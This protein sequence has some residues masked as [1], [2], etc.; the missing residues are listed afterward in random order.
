MKKSRDTFPGSSGLLSN[1]DSGKAETRERKPT[2]GVIPVEVDGAL[3]YDEVFHAATGVVFR[4]LPKSE[5][6]PNGGGWQPSL[7][8]ARLRTSTKLSSRE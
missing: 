4:E 3:P 2:N 5:K 8:L 1:E 7:T 6:T